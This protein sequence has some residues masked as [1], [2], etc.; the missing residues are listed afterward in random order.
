MKVYKFAVT[1]NN[2]VFSFS[3]QKSTL[4]LKNND[5]VSSTKVH[6]D[7]FEIND[8][9]VRCD[10]LH[11]AKEV[12]MYIELKGQDIA[13]AVKQIIRT[14]S[15]LSE[16]QKKQRKICYI[17]CTRSPLTSTEIQNFDRMFRQK[18]NSKLIVKS[19]PYVD[20]Y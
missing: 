17:I 6:V 19:S 9:G 1:S 18:Y 12:E 15:I 20:S 10:Y 11:I 2:K 14:I 7:G 16:D 8:D 13:H 5:E 4:L 3:E